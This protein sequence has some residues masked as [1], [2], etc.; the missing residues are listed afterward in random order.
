MKKL[1]LIAMLLCAAYSAQAIKIIH[2]PY[3]QSVS[4]TEATIIWVTDAKALSWVEV[5]PNDKTHFYQESRQKYYQTYLGKRVFGTLHTV[6]I[7]GLTPGTTYRY[8]V[9]SKEV[10]SQEKHRVTYGH[11][12][13]T[14]VYRKG[15]QYLTTLNPQKESVEFLVLNDIHSKQDKLEALLNN[16]DK[17]TTDFVFF[18]GDMVSVVPSVQTLFEGFIDTSVKRFAS[19]TQFYL[20]RGNHETRGMCAT[21]FLDYFPTPT[22]KPYFTFTHGDTF[23]ILLD[24][25]EDKPDDNLEYYETADYDNYRREE[26]AWLQGVVESEE[27]KS[28]KYRIVFIHMP[29]IGGKKLWHGPSHAS[30]CFLPILNKANVTVLLAG[31]THRYAYHAPNT[32][33]ATF[34]ILVNAHDNALKAKICKDGVMIEAVD[35]EG[36]VKHTH[37]FR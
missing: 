33:D 11:V 15:A 7:T 13:S 29:I 30:E 6:R 31:H 28:A 17:R 8:A 21:S 3:L 35:M 26:A 24:G 1:V 36:K 5:A 27:Y 2:G 14:N 12:A 4:E 20:V 22:N 23:F 10:V 32:T 37:T 25:G 16:Y 34:P 9:A 18:N 19:N